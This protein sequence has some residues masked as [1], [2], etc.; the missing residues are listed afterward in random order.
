MGAGG[1]LSA[2]TGA[3]ACALPGSQGQSTLMVTNYETTLE[4]RPPVPG[5]RPADPDHPTD[6]PR[7]RRAMHHHPSL[8]RSV[9]SLS[10]PKGAPGIKAE[11]DQ[12]KTSKRCRLSRFNLTSPIEARPFGLPRPRP[13]RRCNPPLFFH[14]IRVYSRMPRAYR[15]RW[16]M[17]MGVTSRRYKTTH[18]AHVERRSPLCSHS[19]KPF[20]NRLNPAFRPSFPLCRVGYVSVHYLV[21]IPLAAVTPISLVSVRPPSSSP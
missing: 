11:A 7:R 8:C 3:G 12:G 13:Q 19:P 10:K 2:A 20:P 18:A 15:R 17:T 9:V 4:S 16:M 14:P 21:K 5:P 1:P 6:R